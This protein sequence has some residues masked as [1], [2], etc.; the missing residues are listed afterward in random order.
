MGCR[1][2]T[3]ILLKILIAV[4]CISVCSY[5]VYLVGILYLS[6][7]TTVDLRIGRSLN[8]H[9]PGITICTEI[10]T[11]ILP[12]KIIEIEPTLRPILYGMS[13]FDSI[14]KLRRINIVTWLYI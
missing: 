10:A 2:N 4:G 6:Y 3:R 14:S 9:L 7:P 1:R 13:F 5:Q 8:I 11:T 12:D